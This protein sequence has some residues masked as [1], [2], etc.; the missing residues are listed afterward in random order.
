MVDRVVND[1]GRE[2]EY[3]E[4]REVE[5]EWREEAQRGRKGRKWGPRD[6]Q[7]KSK[8]RRERNRD[9][10][11]ETEREMKTL[12]EE[13]RDRHRHTHAISRRGRAKRWLLWIMVL[14][15][16]EAV[17]LVGFIQGLCKGCRWRALWNCFWSRCYLILLQRRTILVDI[18]FCAVRVS[19]LWMY[20]LHFVFFV[21]FLLLFLLFLLLFFKLLLSLSSFTHQ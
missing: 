3:G 16:R 11:T 15:E 14:K 21:L 17:L 2:G 20:L 7:Q 10:K 18:M 1:E 6:R 9:R 5:E 4:G 8:V 13:G 19:G 12:K